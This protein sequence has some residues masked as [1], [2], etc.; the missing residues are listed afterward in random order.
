MDW[1]TR[2]SYF[3]LIDFASLVLLFGSW[4]VIGFLIDNAPENRPSVSV[5]M[6]QYRRDWMIEMV[7]R[8]PRIFDAQIL[9][10]LRQGTSFFASATMIAI[11]GCL[12][13]LGNLERLIGIATELTQEQDPAI[14][15]EVKVLVIL[16][17]LT[18]AFL[19]FVWSNRL[20][21]YCGVLIAAVPN[22]PKNPLA[23]I[24][25]EKAGEINITAA[26]GFNRGL[27]S[28][29]FGLATAAW[30]LGPE[31]LIGTTLITCLVL[32]RREFASRSRHVLMRPE[33]D[34]SHTQT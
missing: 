20:F 30:L 22:D 31:A 23:L 10:T 13:L 5:L 11:G 19:K 6:A 28:V 18:N 32:L 15:W 24:R 9:A 16:V 7:S 2:F 29:Y 1:L 8:D 4:A 12:A 14:V 3:T 33:Y 34:N 17:F 26:R 27:R 25:A 21:G